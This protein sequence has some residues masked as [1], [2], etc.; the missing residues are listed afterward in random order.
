[1]ICKNEAKVFSMK[2]G[3]SVLFSIGS[4]GLRVHGIC[5]DASP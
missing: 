1:M 2:V 3:E 5:F 4:T